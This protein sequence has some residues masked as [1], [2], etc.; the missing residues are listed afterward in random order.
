ML[1]IMIARHLIFV[2]VAVACL[3]HFPADAASDRHDFVETE[4]PCVVRCA[5]GAVA[6]L[7]GGDAVPQV[8]PE[9]LRGLPA[10]GRSLLD[11]KRFLR[12]HGVSATTSSEVALDEIELSPEHPAILQLSPEWT[13]HG[14]DP[15]SRQG[16]VFAHEDTPHFVLAVKRNGSELLIWDVSVGHDYVPLEELEPFFMGHTMSLSLQPQWLRGMYTLSR[17]RDYLLAGGIALLCGIGFLVFHARQ[18]RRS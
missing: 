7:V 5:L 6:L 12:S 13:E 8:D 1:S 2:L 4:T 15:E 11:V 17:R 14:V 3:V 18:R 10:Q 9:S 16:F